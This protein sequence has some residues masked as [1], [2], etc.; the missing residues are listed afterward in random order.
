M[1]QRVKQRQDTIRQLLDS[2]S[3][4]LD[5]ARAALL[6]LL[7]VTASA[8]TG[9][10]VTAYGIDGSLSREV[11]DAKYEGQE[12]VGDDLDATML[13]ALQSAQK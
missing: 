8:Q 13:H 3:L 1:D 11:V 7:D 4:T 5:T 10:D 12:Q 6:S 2:D 9:P